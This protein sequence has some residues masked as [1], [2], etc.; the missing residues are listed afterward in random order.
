MCQYENGKVRLAGG[1]AIVLFG[2]KEEWHTHIQA[3]ILSYNKEQGLCMLA[4]SVLI[5]KLQ[6][7]L[8]IRAEQLWYDI[9]QE[10]QF[11]ELPIV[12]EDKENVL[13]GSGLRAKRDLSKYTVTAP[14]G[15]VTV[16]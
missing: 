4:G 15:T 10:I 2:N 7:Q 9:K 13:K 8:S 5:S 16:K 1:V 11:T 12:M 14:N 6:Q 3:D